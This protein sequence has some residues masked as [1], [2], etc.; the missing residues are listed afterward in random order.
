M[1]NT[2]PE[3]LDPL[4]KARLRARLSAVRPP[5]SLPRYATAVRPIRAWRLAPVAV[6][7]ALTGILALT[8]FAATGSPNPVVWT[9]RVE[10]VINPPSASPSP[11]GEPAQSESQQATVAPPAHKPTAEATESAEPATSPGRES[12]EPAEDHPSP[13]PSPSPSGDH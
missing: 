3:E 10:T 6:A 7:I 1:S 11:Q 5:P 9:N 4:L 12:P 2:D 8:A 13:N